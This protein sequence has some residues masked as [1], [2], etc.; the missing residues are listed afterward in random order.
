MRAFF[1]NNSDNS[2]PLSRPF[3]DN[4]VKLTNY[5]EYHN[6]VY[7]PLVTDTV[8]V[9]DLVVSV[10]FNRQSTAS[11]SVLDS[12]NELSESFPLNKFLLV[13]SDLVP[14]SA[15]DADVQHFPSALISYG[16]DLYRD[17]VS[18]ESGFNPTTRRYYSWTFN[19][20]GEEN[21]ENNVC[22]LPK[23][24]YNSVLNAIKKFS[25]YNGKKVSSIKSKAGTHSY[26]HGIDTD[27][28]NV[29][30]VGWPTE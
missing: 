20:S 21:L 26:T 24:F 12:V 1:H 3:N 27:N 7:K 18:E 22:V 8:N 30:R 29:K 2:D 19:C 4:V 23:N 6:Y 9:N 11:L 10:F 17:L 5:D 14:R 16:G 15:Y 25:S 13:D 28:L